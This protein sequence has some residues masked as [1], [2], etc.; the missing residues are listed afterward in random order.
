MER[1]KIQH[2]RIMP[3]LTQLVSFLKRSTFE[4]WYFVR[5]DERTV[6]TGYN[7]ALLLCA[8]SHSLSPFFCL[9]QWIT[10]TMLKKMTF[11]LAS[12][13]DPESDWFSNLHT[14]T[15]N[16]TVWI[17]IQLQST[18]SGVIELKCL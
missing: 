13:L 15:L 6:A 14:N 17:H 2:A 12:H 9:I 16:P 11:E 10:T 3:N 8:H 7:V 5:F 1:W 18:I 4:N